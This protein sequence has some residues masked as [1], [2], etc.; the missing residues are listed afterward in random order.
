MKV[1]TSLYRAVSDQAQRE[2]RTI[3]AV[4]SRA[5]RAYIE[6]APEATDA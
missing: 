4:L 6:K 3:T 5:V 2:E 1:P